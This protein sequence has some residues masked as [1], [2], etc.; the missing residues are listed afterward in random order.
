MQT[1]ICVL[2]ERSSSCELT[3]VICIMIFSLPLLHFLL[4]LTSNRFIQPSTG[5]MPL[6]VAA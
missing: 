1:G 4:F 5:C 2:F 6:D 3:D